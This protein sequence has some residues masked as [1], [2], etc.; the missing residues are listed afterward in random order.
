[1]GSLASITC[2]TRWLL[3]RTL[4]SCLQTCRFFSNGVSCTRLSCSTCASALLHSRKDAR[5]TWSS[6]SVL[7][8]RL[9]GGLLGTRTASWC[10]NSASS[11]ALGSFVGFSPF[12]ST[13]T[14]PLDARKSLDAS[15]ARSIMASKSSWATVDCSPTSAAASWCRSFAGRCLDLRCAFFSADPSPSPPCFGMA[16]SDVRLRRSECDAHVR[17]PWSSRSD[18]VN[19][20]RGRAKGTD[21]PVHD[22]DHRQ[23]T[24]AIHGTW[25]RDGRSESREQTKER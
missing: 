11:C 21:G 12:S 19:P 25:R 10:S 1:M 24:E 14:S 22:T 23:D 6:S 3:S 5:S 17:R 15:C 18:G 20:P 13:W 2:T 4:Q 8:S 16:T 7:I 9:Q